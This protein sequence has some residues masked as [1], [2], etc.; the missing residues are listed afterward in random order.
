M[1]RFNLIVFNF[2]HVVTIY[3]Y[4]NDIFFWGKAKIKLSI[5]KRGWWTTRGEQQVF[6]Q[7]VCLSLL[8]KES[9]VKFQ[10]VLP[11]LLLENVLLCGKL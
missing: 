8:Y 6:I 11:L 7:Q 5:Y 9:F 2:V 1:V 10:T 3:C 4:L